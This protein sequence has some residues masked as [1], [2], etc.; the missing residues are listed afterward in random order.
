MDRDNIGDQSYLCYLLWYQHPLLTLHCHYFRHGFSLNWFSHHAQSSSLILL[1]CTNWLKFPSE[2]VGLDS[3][4][5]CVNVCIWVV[6]IHSTGIL[7]KRRRRSAF[8][9]RRLGQGLVFELVN[10]MNNF[11][12]KA[13]FFF[14]TE[15]DLPL[16]RLLGVNRNIFDVHLLIWFHI[17][18]ERVFLL[19]FC[20][21]FIL[22]YLILSVLLCF[23]HWDRKRGTSWTVRRWFL[24]GAHFVCHIK[25]SKHQRTFPVFCFDSVNAYRSIMPS[26]LLWYSHTDVVYVCDLMSRIKGFAFFILFFI[27]T[28][29]LFLTAGLCLY[30]MCI[31]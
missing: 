15:T 4:C 31:I 8:Q 21:L 30:K 16:I 26:T 5:V 7:E 2:E 12:T 1:R 14:P 6:L 22:S 27:P 23:M 17:W 24:V 18:K 25:Y 29:Q 9:V 19:F 13:F 3:R 10:C 11:K 20:S 28:A